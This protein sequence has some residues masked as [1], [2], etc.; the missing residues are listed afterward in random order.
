[1]RP[2]IPARFRYR[3]SQ[4]VSAG[5]VHHEGAGAE[6]LRRRDHARNRA[7]D[8]QQHN[9]HELVRFFVPD[10]GELPRQFAF[11]NLSILPVHFESVILANLNFAVYICESVCIRLIVHD[12]SPLTRILRLAR[13]QHRDFKVLAVP[14]LALAEQDRRWRYCGHPTT[15]PPILADISTGIRRMWISILLMHFQ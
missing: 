8:G 12:V 13:S 15:P 10:F 9:W 14:I 2:E 1:M 6:I 7:N 5:R 3:M 4:D 11:A